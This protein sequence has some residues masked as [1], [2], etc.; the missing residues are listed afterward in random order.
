MPLQDLCDLIQLVHQKCYGILFHYLMFFFPR[1]VCFMLY[2]VFCL[3]K[4]HSR[5]VF[6]LLQHAIEVSIVCFRNSKK[7]N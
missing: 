7:S 3:N 4:V 1:V 2:Q 5:R 6:R